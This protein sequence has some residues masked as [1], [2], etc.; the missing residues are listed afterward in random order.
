MPEQEPPAWGCLATA[1][2]NIVA[3]ASPARSP[4]CSPFFSEKA[5]LS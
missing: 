3:E 2:G 1:P 5:S 4:G